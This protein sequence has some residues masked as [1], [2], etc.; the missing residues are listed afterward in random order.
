MKNMILAIALTILFS[1]LNDFQL[2]MNNRMIE[3]IAGEEV[4]INE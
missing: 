2:E 3:N 1:V 4:E